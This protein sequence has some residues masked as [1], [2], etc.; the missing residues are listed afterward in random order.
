MSN[1]EDRR[2]QAANGAGN[3]VSELPENFLMQASNREFPQ[4][5]PA[6]PTSS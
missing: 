2:A 4:M 6:V 3:A 5:V 1:Q